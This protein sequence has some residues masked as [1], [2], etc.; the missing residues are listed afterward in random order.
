MFLCK[1][2]V[3][4]KAHSLTLEIYKISENFPHNENFSI[5]SQIRRAAY[6]IPSNIIEG[7][8]RGSTKEYLRYVNI[9]VG[10]TTELHYFLYL[11]KDL[12][13]IDQAIYSKLEEH[14]LIVKKMLYGLRNSLK[15]KIKNR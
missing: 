1:L 7:T 10:S 11:S 6:S 13:Y 3:F 15:N 8:S 12:N 2:D 4:K 9:A 5:I 14:C